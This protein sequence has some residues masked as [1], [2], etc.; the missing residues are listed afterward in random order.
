MLCSFCRDKF[1]ETNPI[2]FGGWVIIGPLFSVYANKL[3]A[4]SILMTNDITALIDFYEREK[5]LPRQRVIYALEHAFLS[6]YRKK[7]AGGDNIERLRCEI[8]MAKNRVRI[9]AT[10]AVVEE[11]DVQDRFN[12]LPLSIAQKIKPDAEVGGTIDA[13]VTPKDFG[14]IAFQTARQSMMQSL[15]D[16]EKELLFAEFKDRA[17]DLVAG[18]ITRF[19][20]GDILVSIGK[21]EGV[22]PIRERV[23]TEEY[24]V[25][26]R[27][28]FY[29]VEVREGA[30]GPE[31]VLSRSHPNLIRR[32]F[33]AEVTEIADRTVEIRG[34]ARE[35]GYRTKIAVLSEDPKVDPVGA[36][37]G[38]RGMRVKNIIREL[39]NEKV[40]IIEW[41]ENPVEFV[42]S[43]LNPVEA[44]EISI[45]EE[46]HTINVVVED[47]KELAK[48]IGRR[49]QNARLT[50]RLIGWDIQVRAYDPRQE[51]ERLLAKAADELSLFLGID[52]EVAKGLAS[53]GGTTAAAIIDFDASDIA[54]ALNLPTEDAQAIID[55]A[56]TSI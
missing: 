18:A 44:R 27:M 29:I 39:N 9:F 38:I 11:A 42:C 50:A 5:E 48:A 55:K 56:K 28:R 52:A 23:P 16:A 7:V 25:G 19:E 51:A 26:D 15:R 30:R 34:I 10:V 20:K 31:V 54:E 12:E 1:A 32:L 33:E 53:M 37:V 49:G 43:A 17:G 45:D 2:N 24:N 22:M 6:A 8:N 46:T 47:E 21:Y 4:S 41:S 36:C 35:A 40:D 3:L 14:R 13:D